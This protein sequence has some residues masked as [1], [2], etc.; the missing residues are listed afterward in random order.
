MD[1]LLQAT[2]TLFGTEENRLFP[3]LAGAHV[4]CAARRVIIFI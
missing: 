3:P 4:P 2:Q 1:P